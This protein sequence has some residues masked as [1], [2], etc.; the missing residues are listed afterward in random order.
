MRIR[1]NQRLAALILLGAASTALAA[2]NPEAG[3][4]KAAACIACHGP[5]G[6]SPALPPPTEQWPKLAGQL[7]EYLT[8]QML[9]FKAGRRSNAQMSPQAQAV[10]ES[11]IADIAAF[12]AKQKVKPNEPGD[13]AL[14]AQGEKL[15]FNGKGRPNLVAA[16]VGCHGLDGSG[17]RDWNKT[18]SSLPAVLAPAI[19]GQHASYVAAQL[20]AYRDG[21]RRNERANVMRDIARRLN[22]K[23]I[24]AVSEYVASLTRQ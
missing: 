24:A 22:D 4:K 15:F 21:S 5:D 10:A 17:N 18:M 3:E 9:D 12:F 7:P 19:G 2:G 1:I 11:D 23:D 13:K 20:K 16:C 6:N 8:S 14:I